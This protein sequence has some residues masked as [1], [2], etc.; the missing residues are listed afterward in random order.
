MTTIDYKQLY[1]D[2]PDWPR[3][4]AS[5]AQARTAFVVNGFNANWDSQFCEALKEKFDFDAILDDA[6]ARAY[7]KPRLL[8]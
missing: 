5:L 7:F 6:N 2:D 4:A 8:T 1:S 3:E